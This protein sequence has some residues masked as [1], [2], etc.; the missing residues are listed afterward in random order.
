MAYLAKGQLTLVVVALLTSLEDATDHNK[1]V[2]TT[3]NI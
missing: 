1:M 3:I 2:N